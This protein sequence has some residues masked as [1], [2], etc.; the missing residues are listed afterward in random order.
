MSRSPQLERL[1]MLERYEIILKTLTPKQLAVVAL[2]LDGIQGDDVGALLGIP[3]D[4]VTSRLAYARKCVLKKL[5]DLDVKGRT[6][7]RGTKY[8]HKKNRGKNGR[9][10]L[11][12]GQ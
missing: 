11:D 6:R 5:P 3:T 4:T 2:L 7:L 8:M 1:C 10:N 12:T 9:R